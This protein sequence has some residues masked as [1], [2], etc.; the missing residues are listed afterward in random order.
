MAFH[1]CR[2]PDLSF[3][4]F[5]GETA[6]RYRFGNEDEL[7]MHTTGHEDGWTSPGVTT[8]WEEDPPGSAGVPPAQFL[9]QPRPYPPPRSTGKDAMPLPRPGHAVSAGR[10]T[11]CRIA[12]KLSGNRRERMRAGRPRSRGVSSRWCGGGCLAGDFSESRTASVGKLPFAPEPGPRPPRLGRSIEKDHPFNIV[13]QEDQDGTPPHARLT[14]AMMAH[15]SQ[16]GRLIHFGKHRLEFKRL[17]GS[18]TGAQVRKPVVSRKTPVHPVHRCESKIYLCWTLDRCPATR[19]RR[20]FH[21]S[22]AHYHPV[23]HFP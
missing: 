17:S 20:L 13:A 2:A 15:G 14:P 12:G 3:G 22:S 9:A 8:A 10:V 7:P 16:V 5:R 23:G 1:A 21:A 11:G 19:R 18:N 4:P 6:G